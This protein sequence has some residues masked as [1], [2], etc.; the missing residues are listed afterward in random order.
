MTTRLT[1]E[2]VSERL[3]IRLKETN[4]EYT[5]VVSTFIKTGGVMNFSCNHCGT[6][7][8]RKYNAV[9]KMGI[10]KCK[11]IRQPKKEYVKKG[12]R[13]IPASQRVSEIIPTL[14]PDPTTFT[15]IN[16]TM[17][18]YCTECN[19][20]VLKRLSD[21]FRGN[22]F[23]KDKP[24]ELYILRIEYEGITIGYK[25][26]I[27]N[28]TAT[29]RCKFINKS[30]ELKLSV[31]YSIT[32]DGH[33]IAQ[34]EKDIKVLCD[35]GGYISKDIMTGGYTETFRPSYLPIVTQVILNLK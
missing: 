4:S 12:R 5:P 2:E 31:L 3:T 14:I 1:K 19:N 15:N 22:G 8:V 16:K 29:K 27:T 30:T 17:Q 20:T 21:V 35:Q 26:G 34:A 11:C 9:I 23:R 25:V 10:S 6:V 28:K 7:V 13:I 32:S 33:T 18:M 24:A